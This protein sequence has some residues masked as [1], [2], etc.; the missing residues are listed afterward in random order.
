LKLQIFIAKSALSRAK[1]LF[2]DIYHKLRLK[3]RVGR[4]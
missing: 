1:R 4:P 2:L 3:E